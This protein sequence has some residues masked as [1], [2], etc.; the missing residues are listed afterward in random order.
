MPAPDLSTVPHFY[1]GYINH[2]NAADAYEAT[3]DHLQPLL[4]QVS[5]LDESDWDFRY[6][7][8]KWSIKELVQHVID[9]ERIFCHRALSIAREDGHE[10]PGFDE[11]A[12]AAVSRASE[13]S[14]QALLQEL[15]AVGTSTKHLFASFDDNQL[16]SSGIANGLPISV[17]AIAYIIAG[18]AKHHAQIVQLRYRNKSYQ[19]EAVA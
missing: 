16:Q 2:L 4:V 12:Y 18:H 15:T 11:E 1:H 17:N 14:S 5:A 3:A 13:R 19:H 9:S 10:L 6:A 8:G 7:P